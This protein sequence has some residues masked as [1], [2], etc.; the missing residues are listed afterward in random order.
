MRLNLQNSSFLSLT[1]HFYMTSLLLIV[2]NNPT[3]FAKLL[4][5]IIDCSFLHDLSFI[6]CKQWLW[7]LNM[8]EINEIL[9]I[10]ICF[11]IM[12]RAESLKL[13][14]HTRARRNNEEFFVKIEQILGI[15]NTCKVLSLCFMLKIIYLMLIFE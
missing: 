7:S 9:F 12:M 14:F 11:Y 13:H 4:I 6:N 1:A 15:Q 3:K 5:F 10:L 8:W 2:N